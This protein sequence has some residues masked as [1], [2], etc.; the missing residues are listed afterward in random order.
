MVYS[1]IISGRLYRVIESKK[2]EAGYKQVIRG[3]LG[4]FLLVGRMLDERDCG[5]HL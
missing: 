2:G 1:S 3:L 4:Y 5:Y